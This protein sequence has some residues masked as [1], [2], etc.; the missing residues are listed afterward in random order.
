MHPGLMH[1]GRRKRHAGRRTFCKKG[2][3]HYPEEHIAS[4]VLIRIR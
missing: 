1:A 4:M 3:E 2:K